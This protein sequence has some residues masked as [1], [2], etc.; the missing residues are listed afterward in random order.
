[1]DITRLY[2]C[3]HNKVPMVIPDHYLRGTSG[4]LHDLTETQF[5]ELLQRLISDIVFQIFSIVSST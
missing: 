5:P 1:M 4:R 3:G 2:I